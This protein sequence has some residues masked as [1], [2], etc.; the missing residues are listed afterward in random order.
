MR[1]SAWRC[2]RRRQPA[3]RS[4]ADRRRAARTGSAAQPLNAPVP[5][6]AG[7]PEPARIVALTRRH[8]DGLGGPALQLYVPKPLQRDRRT[9]RQRT[10]RAH[11]AFRCEATCRRSRRA[12]HHVPSVRDDNGRLLANL[13]RDLHRRPGNAAAAGRSQRRPADLLRRG[14]AGQPAQSALPAAGADISI[15]AGLARCEPDYGSMIDV[16]SRPA[17]PTMRRCS[18]TSKRVSAR[19]R[20]QAGSLEPVRSAVSL[21]AAAAPGVSAVQ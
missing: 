6:H 5:V 16:T 20:Q 10:E 1:R 19:S 9:R 7:D 18:T 17:K 13:G 4:A 8:L 15:I 21:Q 3:I 11:S 14:L 2:R 12:G